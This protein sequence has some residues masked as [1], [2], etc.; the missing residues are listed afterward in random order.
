[1][2]VHRDLLLA[3]EVVLLK[4]LLGMPQRFERFRLSAGIRVIPFR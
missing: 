2:Q 1:M 3:F 4:K